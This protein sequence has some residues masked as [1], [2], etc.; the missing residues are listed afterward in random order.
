MQE[1][2]G[3]DEEG[4]DLSEA[5]LGARGNPV[6]LHTGTVGP[7]AGR[8]GKKTDRVG[9]VGRNGHDDVAVEV[10]ARLAQP[11]RRSQ[12]A[13][14]SA[15]VKSDLSHQGAGDSERLGRT[16]GRR[17]SQVEAL[18]ARRTSTHRDG[19]HHSVG[20]LKRRRGARRRRGML[21][22]SGN[23]GTNDHQEDADEDSQPKDTSHGTRL[24][25]SVGLSPRSVGRI[26][27]CLL[28]TPHPDA[29]RLMDV[30]VAPEVLAARVKGPVHLVLQRRADLGKAVPTVARPISATT[31]DLPVRA[32]TDPTVTDVPRVHVTAALPI[33]ATTAD[34]P[35]R[36]RID[37]A[38]TKVNDA[39]GI[40]MTE[41]R[42]VVQRAVTTTHVVRVPLT[43]RAGMLPV[44]VSNES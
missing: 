38:A 7:V 25:T 32:R 26:E 12:D 10:D 24:M 4:T 42:V 27:Q 23:G 40:R 21:R 17:G 20:R 1:R 8:L 19:G 28:R 3:R 34:L 35:V 15:L 14:A 30:P 6:E 36:A 5:A 13:Y 29:P 22:G 18:A 44:D 11:S 39:R 2:D 41:S 43:V 31:A 33:S 37:L 9:L 16:R